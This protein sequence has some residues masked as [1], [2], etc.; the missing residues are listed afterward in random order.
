MNYTNTKH[1]GRIKTIVFDMGGVLFSD[2]GGKICGILEKEKG[3]DQEIIRSV[4]K[5]FEKKE[6]LRG[7]ITDQEFW[8]WVKKQLPENYDTDYIR[9]RYYESYALD[10]DVL[11]LVK[12]LRQNGYKLFI[13]SGNMKTRVEYL[14]NTYSYSQYF[15]KMI[16]SYELGATKPEPKF[17]EALIKSLDCESNEAVLID[18]K[19][20]NLN[21][22]KKEYGMDSALYKEGQIEDLENQLI[23]LGINI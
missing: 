20:D 10:N 13:F 22:L 4:F 23:E 14:E 11:E 1:L 21:V 9:K 8:Q 2:G 16:Y 6:S 15:D 19:Q 3:Y 12:K 5:S 7:N 18:D 17:F